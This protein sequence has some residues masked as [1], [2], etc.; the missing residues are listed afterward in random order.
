MRDNW[1]PVTKQGK[2]LHAVCRLKGCIGTILIAKKAIWQ[3][4]C[5][6][7]GCPEFLGRARDK[8]TDRQRP[9]EERMERER[10]KERQ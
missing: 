1:S 5:L 7:L 2:Y 3:R 10:G 8:Q 4:Q 9:G 6:F